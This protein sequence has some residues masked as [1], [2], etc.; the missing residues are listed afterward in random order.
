[1]CRCTF[2]VGIEGRSDVESADETA[3]PGPRK[4]FRG[5]EKII[6]GDSNRGECS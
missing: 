2:R 6:Q 5:D 1:M 4:F 3:S